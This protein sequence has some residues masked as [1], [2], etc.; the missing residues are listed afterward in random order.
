MRGVAIRRTTLDFPQV[1]VSAK[2][3]RWKLPIFFRSFEIMDDN[4]RGFNMS[5]GFLGSFSHRDAIHDVL[6]RFR[7]HGDTVTSIICFKKAEIDF[8]IKIARRAQVQSLSILSIHGTKAFN[9]KDGAASISAHVSSKPSSWNRFWRWSV[10]CVINTEKT[11]V[12]SHF[13][14]IERERALCEK[15][16]DRDLI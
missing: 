9:C 6:L 12:G 15:N 10:A 5:H 7:C 1:P 14:G 13:L 8:E 3:G 16:D 11:H 4:S 2:S